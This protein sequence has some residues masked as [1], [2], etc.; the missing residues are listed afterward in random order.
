MKLIGR[1][2][3]VI[4][5]AIASTA[6]AGNRRYDPNPDAQ[7]HCADQASVRSSEIANK[8][9]NDWVRA[10]NARLETLHRCQSHCSQ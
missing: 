5:I 10:E 6:V 7:K 2:S 1:L 3:I 8:K 9:G 4:S